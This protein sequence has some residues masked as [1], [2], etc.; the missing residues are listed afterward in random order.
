MNKELYQISNK[1][2]RHI[3]KRY[4]IPPDTCQNYVLEIIVENL[5]KL[6]VMFEEC[7]RK[8]FNFISDRL[9]RKCGV[10]Q[11]TIDG[12]R[13]W[14]SPYLEAQSVGY[15]TAMDEYF[16][17]QEL[18]PN[19]RQKLEFLE[20]IGKF[21]LN[22]NEAIFIH[23]SFDGYNIYDPDDHE[24][25]KNALPELTIG[26]LQKRFFDRLCSK[27]KKNSPFREED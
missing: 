10:Y 25:F 18:E 8:V 5:E 2:S 22:K 3:S 4:S 23:L 6:D 12:K 9:R 24:V 14:R 1:V 13:M 17:E 11:T 7:P 27:L 19:V 20:N 21:D 26:Y 15:D 16:P